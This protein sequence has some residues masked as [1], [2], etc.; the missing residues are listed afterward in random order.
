MIDPDQSIYRFE[1]F[2]LDAHKRLLLR[3]GQPVALPSKALDL[4]LT[5]IESQGRALT[6]QEIMESLWSDQIVEDANLTVTMSH[7]RKALG[8]KASDHRFIVTIPGHGY[9]FVGELKPRQA[10]ILEQ[11]T[12]SEIVIDEAEPDNPAAPAALAQTKSVGRSDSLTQRT[13]AA[14]VR[15]H[16]R[17]YLLIAPAILICLA[18]AVGY[19]LLR[20]RK[21]DAPFQKIRLTRLTNSG[22]VAAAA[23]SLDH[24]LIAYVLGEADGNSLWVQQVG[25]AS[26]IRIAPPTIAE[27]WGLTVS[28]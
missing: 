1:D 11:L 14:G 18:L 10:L 3:N 5:L 21:A 25:T 16:S 19:F 13:V 6:K 8:E 2:E 4:L 27:V 7:L 9:R 15:K 28:P 17:L 26:N 12:V 20:S 23:I 24:K 22:R